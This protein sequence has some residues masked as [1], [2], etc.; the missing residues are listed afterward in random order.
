M[1]FNLI[2]V[3]LLAFS[4]TANSLPYGFFLNFKK[5]SDT[6]AFAGGNYYL[7]IYDNNIQQ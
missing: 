5:F 3:L 2:V 7:I 6:D 1:N 4:V